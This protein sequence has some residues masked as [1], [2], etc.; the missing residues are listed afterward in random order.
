MSAQA[1][2]AILAGVVSG[3][4]VRGH[5]GRGRRRRAGLH[6]LG[7]TSPSAAA[8]GPASATPA[9]G[10]RATPVSLQPHITDADL[11]AVVNEIHEV[12]DIDADDLRDLLEQ[13]EGGSARAEDQAGPLGTRP[14]AAPS[15]A[16]IAALDGDATV[17]R[18]ANTP[19]L[20]AS[21]RREPYGV[22]GTARPSQP[23]G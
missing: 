17:A 22:L 21:V 23:R 3:P 6:R 7:L 18:S 2:T 8:S 9:G 4:L 12:Y 19:M 1:E 13:L 10:E 20:P 15:A 11:R 14:E 16:R 5:S